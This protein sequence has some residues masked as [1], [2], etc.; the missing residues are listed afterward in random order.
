MTNPDR[1][2]DQ[3]LSRSVI[4]VMSV[5]PASGAS[6]QVYLVVHTRGFREGSVQAVHNS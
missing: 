5:E 4:I 6:T 2:D 1:D 3:P